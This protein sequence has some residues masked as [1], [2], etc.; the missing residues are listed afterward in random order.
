MAT[1]IVEDGT[2]LSNANTYVSIAEADA[3]LEE[4]GTPATW[5]AATEEQ[6]RIACKKATRYMDLHYVW[7]GTRRVV[8]QALGFPQVGIED[9]DGNVV[10]CESVPVKA[11]QCCI[12]LASRVI[13]GDDL[14][15]VEETEASIKRKKDVIGPLTEEVEYTGGETPAIF[16]PI[17]DGLVEEFVQSSS[18][19]CVVQLR[20]AL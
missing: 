17:A 16:Y 14:M 7:A 3:Y 2:G 1:F 8:D 4:F 19:S 9:R 6:K 18:N 20:K 13:E 5:A 15:A 10:S 12:Y 11:K